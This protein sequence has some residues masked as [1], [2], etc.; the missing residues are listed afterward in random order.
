MK[1]G[2]I[3]IGGGSP[4]ADALAAAAVRASVPSRSGVRRHFGAGGR[5][6]TPA[7]FR[8][9][10]AAAVVV[11]AMAPICYARMVRKGPTDRR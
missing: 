9:A 5:P 11:P 3:A 10:P 1:M 2:G 8:R 7:R 6:L 4:G